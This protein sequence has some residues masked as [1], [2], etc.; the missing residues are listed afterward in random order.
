MGFPV[1]QSSYSSG[2]LDPALRGRVDLAKFRTGLQTMLNWY[3]LVHG[4]ATTR[5]GFEFIDELIDSSVVGRL[6]RFKFST[7]DTYALE[8]GALKMRV[9]RNGGYVLETAKTITGITQANPGVVTTSGSHGYLT[10]DDVFL[11]GA[12]G[13]TQVNGRRFRVTVLSATTYSI[14]VSTSAYTAWASGGTSARYYTLATPYTAA[15]L[16]RIKFVQSFDKMTICHPSHAPR[17]LTRTGHAAW[18]MM[19]ML[20]VPQQ[21]APDTIAVSSGGTTEYYAVTAINDATGEESLQSVHVGASGPTVTLTITPITGCS[22]YTIYRRKNGVYGLIGTAKAPSAGASVTFT[23]ATIAP[24]FSNTPPQQRNPFASGSI[25]SAVASSGGSGYV[26]PV[27]TVNDPSGF[28]GS[29]VLTPT[30]VAGV[31]TAVAVTKAGL[32]LT[33]PTVTIIDGTGGGALIQL[34]MALDG[35]SKVVGNDAETG[36]PIMSPTYVISSATVLDGGT[37][38]GAGSTVHTTYAGFEVGFGPTVDYG[39]SVITTTVA[40]GVITAATVVNPGTAQFVD[41]PSFGFPTAFV[42]ASAGTGAIITLTL[43]SDA[44]VNPSVPTHW[45]Q[46][47]WFGATARNPQGLWSSQTGNLK[48]MSVSS[49]TRD[50]DAI[51]KTLVSREVNEVRSMVP[52]SDLLL[53]TSGGLWVG[54]AAGS[55]GVTPASLDLVPNIESGASHVPPI[56]INSDVLFITDMS[57][58]VL[59]VQ[60]QL[61]TAK[62]GAVDL[63]ILSRHLFTGY[64]IK[65]WASAPSPHQ[66]IWAVR[67]DG[68]LLSFTYMKEQ[69]IYGWARHDTQGTFE[70]ICSVPE[71][72]EDAVYAIVKRTVGGVTKRYVERMKSRVFSSLKESWC[73]D[74]GLRYG[75][76][77]ATVISGLR[78]LEGKTVSALADGVVRGPFVVADGAITLPVAASVAI[79]GLGYTCDLETLPIEAGPP[80]A[81]GKLKRVVAASLRL[82]KARGLKVG[83][84]AENLVVLMAGAAFGAVGTVTELFT[85]FKRVLIP[86]SWN[87]SGSIFIRQ[88]YPLPATLLADVPE[89]EVGNAS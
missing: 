4:G 51:T 72:N 30:V 66:L 5:A 41:Y 18:T 24:D 64:T 48:N 19:A 82:L 15:Q 55:V 62:Y 61:Q 65:E 22:L 46:R 69:D 84:N 44:T 37:G 76:A 43:G 73:V 85:G 11:S 29:A 58:Q 25:G 89:I 6:I 63:S 12:V 14:G 1:L 88:E 77:P 26:S 87:T 13:M 40:A 31:I 68:V 34:N 56:A 23:D 83:P 39:G 67:S 57:N 71:G 75:G 47:Q 80:T 59:D 2:E 8:F 36:D 7:T 35:G 28:G 45:A 20:F 32:G 27:L 3:S 21:A 50:T 10:G 9:I 70:S 53:F 79:V 42:A 17:E 49:P 33:A 74:C 60:Y 78:H 81:Q 54:S 52:M 38:Y 16:P 86:A